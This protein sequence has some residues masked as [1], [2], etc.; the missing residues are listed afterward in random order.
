MDS[1]DALPLACVINERF[2][3]L[4]GGISPSIKVMDDLNKI[5]RFIE[6]PEDGPL[7]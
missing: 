2:I 1:F 7:W 4:H 3:C 5:T 6:T